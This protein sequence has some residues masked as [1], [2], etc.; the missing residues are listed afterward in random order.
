MSRSLLI[1]V[2]VSLAGGMVLGARF[3]P[4]DG[5]I[6]A[7]G[8]FVLACL[9]LGVAH[10]VARREA[11]PGPLRRRLRLVV[12]IALGIVVGSVTLGALFMF[13]SVHDAWVTAV[14]AL[15]SGIVAL[16]AAQ[17]LAAPTVRDVRRVRDGLV[18]IGEGRDPGPLPVG[19]SGE[20]ADLARAAALMRERLA[21]REAEREAAERAR[22]DLVAAVSHDLRT[23]LSALQ[24]LSDAIADGLG[25]E[26]ERRDDARR[27][28]AHVRA[29][30]AL[31]DDL[32]EIA[33][34]EAKD[35]RW[36]MEQVRLEALVEETVD[37]LRPAAARGARLSAELP[38]DLPPLRANPEKLQRVLFNLVQNALRHTPSDGSVVVRAQAAAGG[39]AVEV[40]V[41]DTGSGIPA[42]DRERVFE[43]FYRAGAEGA[44]RSDGNAGL[45]LAISRA[46]VEAHGGR[47]WVAD[48][49]S[50]TRVRFSIP[51]AA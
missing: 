44:A 19:G 13:V 5:I 22:R 31:V 36:T 46:I 37:A 24:L 2:A 33:R 10:L 14:A 41:A 12:L 20:V 39:E 21:E 11:E 18:A 51:A 32:F 42:A 1:A 28:G 7:T 25:T 45:G 49:A 9:A 29:L 47:I 30:G 6:T 8:L 48:A 3:A 23:P 26:T 15:L 16:R 17:L 34:I 40:E 43:T 4:Q 50:G 38:G 35:I 27:M